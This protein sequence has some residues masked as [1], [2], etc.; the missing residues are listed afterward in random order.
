MI[1]RRV[2]AACCLLAVPTAACLAQSYTS[3]QYFDNRWYITPF[4]TYINADSNRHADNGWGGGLAIGKPISPSWNIELRTQYEEL[5]GKSN[6]PFS[7][8]KFKIWSGSLDAQWFFMGRQ[9]F[10]LWQSN[11]IQPYLV[12]GIGAID[13][14]VDGLFINQS[15]TGFMANAGAGIVWPFSTWG[16]LVGDIRYRYDDNT[17]S[18]ALVNQGHAHDWLFTV[19]LQIP[20]GPPPVVAQAAAPSPPP[21]MQP[22][23]PPPP[24]PVR[25]FELASTGTFFFDKAQLTP[26]GRD[27]VDALVEELKT[28][29]VKPSSIVVVGYT[30][31]LGPA[32]HNQRL[33]VAR[34]NAVRDEMV[35]VGVPPNVIQTE[36]RGATN[37]KVTE[38]DCKAQGKAKN[39]TALIACL[40][41]NRRVEIN[42]TG[43]QVQ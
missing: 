30:D 41:P 23:P 2:F 16:R 11:S 26:S 20:F 43:Q 1:D 32:D 25:K 9:G 18:R 27:R 3:D 12:G 6:G 31:P 38:A 33:S 40:E 10:R 14:K 17:S 35:R 36:G 8:D 34:A 42:V 15:K 28:T 4:G 24:P 13:D 22:P 5:D 37:F 7:G 19:G 29:N 21:S 39:R